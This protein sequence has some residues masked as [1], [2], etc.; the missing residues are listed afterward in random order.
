MDDISIYDEITP[1]ERWISERDRW[2][3]VI[4][5]CNGMIDLDE[6][7]ALIEE[8][9]EPSDALKAKAKAKLMAAFAEYLSTL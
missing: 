2:M 9:G 6:C 4:K 3:T 5:M 7:G 8:H 1:V